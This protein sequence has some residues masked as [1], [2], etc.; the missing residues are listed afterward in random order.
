MRAAFHGVQISYAGSARQVRFEPSIQGDC[1][2]VYAEP[3]RSKL[4][5]PKDA[6]GNITMTMIEPQK[7]IVGKARRKCASFWMNARRC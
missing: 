5:P 2:P 4:R 7:Q 1:G 3:I 6:S